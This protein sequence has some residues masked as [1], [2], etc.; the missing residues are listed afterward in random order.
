MQDQV[1]AL[2]ERQR[3]AQPIV[4]THEVVQQRKINFNSL[5]EQTRREVLSSL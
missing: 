1:L 5:Y 3:Q 2:M 4:D